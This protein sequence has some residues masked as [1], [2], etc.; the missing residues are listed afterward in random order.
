MTKIKIISRVSLSDNQSGMKQNAY[1]LTNKQESYQVITFV[2][3]ENCSW[4]LV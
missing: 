2:C 1:K 3:I 4:V